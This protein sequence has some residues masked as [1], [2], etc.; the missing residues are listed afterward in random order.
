MR[1][2]QRADPAPGICQDPSTCRELSWS[3]DKFLRAWFVCSHTHMFRAR[4]QMMATMPVRQRT[5]CPSRHSFSLR[6]PE[7][8]PLTAVPTRKAKSVRLTNSTGMP[9]I[10][11]KYRT[12]HSLA[13]WML[14]HG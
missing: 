3:R 10:L 6:Y 8:A 5:A 2:S 12:A 9:V 13:T 14:L 7:I 1:G 4:L 11:A